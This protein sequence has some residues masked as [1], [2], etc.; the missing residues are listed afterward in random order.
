MVI[1][2][3]KRYEMREMRVSLFWITGRVEERLPIFRNGINATTPSPAT[4]PV[5]LPSKFLAFKISDGGKLS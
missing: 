3:K 5:L 1:T 4:T 2:T